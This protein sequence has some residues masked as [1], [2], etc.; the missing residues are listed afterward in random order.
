VS[1]DPYAPSARPR[2]TSRVLLLV[3][4]GAVLGGVAIFV[5][6]PV[7]LFLAVPLLLAPL[8]ATLALPRS[9]VRA[10]VAWTEEG[11][12]RE[13]RVRGRITFEPPVAPALVRLRWTIPRPLASAGPPPTVLGKDPASFE[14]LLTAPHPCLTDLPLP[15]VTLEDPLG[16]LG[17]PV[18]VSGQPLSLER[19]PPEVERLGAANLR[20]TSPLPGEVRSHA[21]GATGEFFA[22]RPAAPTDTPRQINWRAT[23]RTGQLR[24]NDYLLDRTGDVILVLDARPTPLGRERDEALLSVARAGAIGIASTLLRAKSRV[25]LAVYREFLT[26]VPL[27]TGRLQRHRIRTLLERS[28][29]TEP[30]GPSERLAVSMRQYFPPGVLVLLFSPIATEEQLT[31][32]PHLRRRGYPVVLVSASP[33]PTLV[34]P[35]ETS[36]ED[37]LARRLLALERRQRISEAWRE[38]P[39]VDWDDYWS[40]GAL[41]ELLRRPVAVG[42]RR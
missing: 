35:G 40:L 41:V 23:A 19:F 13:V 21:L 25:G 36:R 12:G 26:A 6:D 34:P 33:V 1:A 18:P 2:W 27:G 14:L 10:H 42:G 30:E 32:L 31:V 28:G 3:G 39:A 37:G 24:A 9:P 38:A 16:L 15:R 7:P 29:T 17:T 5:R 20:R 4:P 11:S 8:A 22:I